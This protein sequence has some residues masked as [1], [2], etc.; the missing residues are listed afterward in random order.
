MQIEGVG[1][2]RMIERRQR[3]QSSISISP[4][5]SYVDYCTVRTKQKM[6]GKN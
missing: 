4:L 5:Q 3:R 1:T 6:S 2:T